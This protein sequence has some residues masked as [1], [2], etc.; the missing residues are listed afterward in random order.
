MVATMGREAMQAQLA[1]GVLEGCVELMRPMDPAPIDAPHDLFAGFA[2]GGQHLMAIVAQLLRINVRHDLRED[3]RGPRVDRTD[4]AEQH[5]SREAAPGAILEP[6]LAVEAFFALALTLAERTYGEARTLPC[7]PPSRAGQGKAPE[8]GGVCREHKDL[9]AACLGLE[10]GQ[11]KRTISEVS[12]VGLQTPGRAIGA[13]RLFF[14]TSRTLSRPR[15]TP[16]ARAKTVAN[17]RQLPGE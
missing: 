16:V 10:R 4:H 3:F 14:S 17:S 12:R 6:R 5:P 8:D 13:Y 15:W 7:T 9:T 11:C 1:L 2:A